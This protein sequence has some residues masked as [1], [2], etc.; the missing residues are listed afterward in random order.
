M[1]IEKGT[2]LS[3]KKTVRI[4]AY[5]KREAKFVDNRE[6][7]ANE[8]HYQVKEN[9][10]EITQWLCEEEKAV[11]PAFAEGLPVTGLGDYALAKGSYVA[12]EL[13]P[14][15]E[16]IGRYAFY[17]CFSLEKLT[18]HTAIGDVGTGAFTGCHKVRHL[19]VT[20]VPG[21]RSCFHDILSEFSEEMSVD[22]HG[23]QEAKLMFPEFYEEGIENTPARILMTQVHGSGLYYRNCFVNRELN[24]REYDSRF[25]MAKAQES[26]DFLVRL[27]MGRLFYPYRLER[28]AKEEYQ[29]YLKAHLR[30]AGEYLIGQQNMEELRMLTEDYIRGEEGKEV[31]EKWILR[32]QKEQK[33]EMLSYFMDV[34]HQRYPAKKT[35]FE[36]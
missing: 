20:Q 3:W 26:E 11:I 17:N 24:F 30:A 9:T 14:T 13:P 19:D 18:F 28:K 1:E 29:A 4:N 23:E 8:F 32:A 5:E 25:V 10:V 12:I 7:T 2:F 31:L 35:V 6:M 16:K 36:L 22:Y 21:A 15:L 34:R 33:A 27:V